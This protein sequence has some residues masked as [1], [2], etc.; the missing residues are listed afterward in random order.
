MPQLSQPWFEYP[1]NIRWR[2]QIMKLLIM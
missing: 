1:N 2:V